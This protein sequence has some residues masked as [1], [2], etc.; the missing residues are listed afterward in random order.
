[1]NKKSRAAILFL[2][3]AFVFSGIYLY[4]ENN[5]LQKSEY[6]I[7]SKKLPQGFCGFKIAHISDYHNSK[8]EKLAESLAEETRKSKPDIIVV[9]GDLI[10][11]RHT[12]IKN[13]IKL[14]KIISEI[15]PIYYV[16]GNHEARIP[17]EYQ[18]L[19][20]SLEENGVTV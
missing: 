12:N 6:V 5:S 7:R 10:D 19:K 11:S 20:T 3:A 4:Y 8:S 1:M 2:A 13:S 18:K 17:E 16:P 9:T 15:A 14:I